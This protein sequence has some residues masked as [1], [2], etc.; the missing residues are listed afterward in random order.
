MTCVRQIRQSLVTILLRLFA[1]VG[2]DTAIDIKYMTIN[3]IRGMR[4]KEHSGSSEF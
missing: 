4:G 3:G 2:E 1:D